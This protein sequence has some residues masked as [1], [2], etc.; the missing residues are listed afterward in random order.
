MNRYV[1]GGSGPPGEI[2]TWMQTGIVCRKLR[3]VGGANGKIVEE[4]EI[5]TGAIEALN[6][7]EKRAAIETGQDQPDGPDPCPFDAK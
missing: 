6:S 5:D 2:F 1:F 4:Y 7:I 3:S